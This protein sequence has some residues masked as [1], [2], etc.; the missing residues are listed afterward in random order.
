MA[1]AVI[2]VYLFISLFLPYRIGRLTPTLEK[3]RSTSCNHTN[4]YSYLPDHPHVTLWQK[5]TPRTLAVHD[6]STFQ[7]HGNKPKSP[8]ADR[9][10]LLA[11]S[12]KVFDVT[13]GA[14][15]YGPGKC[16]IHTSTRKFVKLK[17]SSQAGLMATLQD[18]ML[19]GECQS[20]LSTL[21]RL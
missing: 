10:I 3:A 6:G 2:A 21:V 1:L 4:S 19:V 14:H 17:K 13:K 9:K 15:F 16:H 11:I 5:Y 8:P 18:E 7:V 12:G 20:S